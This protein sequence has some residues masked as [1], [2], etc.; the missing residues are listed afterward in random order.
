M[1]A[2]SFL[3][4]QVTLLGRAGA[5]SGARG[6]RRAP[7]V[8]RAGFVPRHETAARFATCASRTRVANPSVAGL[9]LNARG[10]QTRVTTGASGEDLS[11]IHISE[12]TR[13]GMNSY[14]VFCLKKKTPDPHYITLLLTPSTDSDHTSRPRLSSSLFV[15]STHF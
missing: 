6:L 8:T 2:A 12:P 7:C 1:A 11:P 13:L 5:P 10:F 4:T 9:S 15:H 14:A 3:A